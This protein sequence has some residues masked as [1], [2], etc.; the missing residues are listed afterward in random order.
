MKVG[1]GPQPKSGQY[2]KVHYIGTLKDGSEF[3]ASYKRN[4][5]FEFA[6]GQ[7]QVIPGWDEGVMTMKVGGRS[8][9]TIPYNL[10]Y[11]EEGRPPVIP[12]KADLIFDI[13]LLGVS[14][15][16]TMGGM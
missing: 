8:K 2:V 12:P 14:D 4:Q 3:D 15:T 9:L 11:G 16:P 13:E 6:I 1:T 7:G 10:A 5:P